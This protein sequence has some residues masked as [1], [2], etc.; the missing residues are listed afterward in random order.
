MNVIIPLTSIGRGAPEPDLLRKLATSDR[1]LLESFV[2][3]AI[4]ALDAIDG[5]PDLE[6][7]DPCGQ[8]DEDE[9]NTVTPAGAGLYFRGFGPGCVISDS[10]C[11]PYA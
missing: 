10:D 5:D 11:D 1:R 4:D 7:D 6:E 8:A 3:A 2:S 9:L